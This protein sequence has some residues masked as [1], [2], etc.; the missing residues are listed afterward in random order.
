[1]EN[2]ASHSDLSL[3]FLWGIL[4]DEHLTKMLWRFFFLLLSVSCERAEDYFTSCGD[5]MPH[6]LLLQSLSLLACSSLL[7][8]ANNL[9]AKQII[10]VTKSHQSAARGTCWYT[11][12]VTR[13]VAKKLH[14]MGAFKDK[15]T[16]CG[17]WGCCYCLS[18]KC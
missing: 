17:K 12:L 11:G 10:F 2:T 15:A 4:L 8:S 18:E 3:Q 6:K 16:L 1:M 7:L 14:Y 5:T 9:Q 13:G